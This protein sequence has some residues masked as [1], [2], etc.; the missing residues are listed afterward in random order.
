MGVILSFGYLVF[1]FILSAAL[2]VVIAE[3]SRRHANLGALIASLPLISLFAI[4]WMYYEKTP[5]PQIAA[6]MSAT[7]WYVL[8]SLPMFL[9]MPALLRA[10]WGFYPALFANLALT[11]LAYLALRALLPGR[12]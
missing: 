8:P 5:L 11:L 10:G 2:I 4:L 1:K 6:H 12:L 3:I 9:L 7:F